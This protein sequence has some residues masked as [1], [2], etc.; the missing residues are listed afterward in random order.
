MSAITK[1]AAKKKKGTSAGTVLPSGIGPTNITN[2]DLGTG[3]IDWSQSVPTSELEGAVIPILDQSGSDPL[4]L[5][6]LLPGVGPGNAPQSLG[7][8]VSSVASMPVAAQ[9]QLAQVLVAADVG[10]AANKKTPYTT[11]EIQSALTTALKEA[12][13]NKSPS[14][15]DFLNQKIG[16]VQAAGIAS[17]TTTS[18][19]AQTIY[20][21][22]DIQATA[23]AV[24]QSVIG[25]KLNANEMQGVLAQMNSATGAKAQAEAAPVP[26]TSTVAGTAGGAVSPVGAGLKQGRTDQGVDYTGA[27]PLYA[28]GSGTILSTSAAGWPGG[29]TYIALKLDNPP[30]PTHD[31]VYYAEGI[32]PGV[33]PGDKVS[34]GQVIGQATG[35]KGGIEIGWG[36][37][38]IGTT[39]AKSTSG[40]TEGQVTSE[41]QHFLSFISGA[42]T[43][44]ATLA[45]VPTGSGLTGDFATDLLN[46]LGA[47]VTPNN[48]KALDAWHQ[49][50]GGNAAFN[51]FNTTQSMTGATN[52]NKVGVKNYAS[53]QD[54]LAATVKALQTGSKSYA[55]ILAALK[56]GNNAIAVADAVGNSQWGTNGI[57]MQSVIVGGPNPIPKSAVSGAAP[58]PTT[59][60]DASS[61]IV[62]I[63]SDPS[64]TEAATNFLETQRSPDYQANN[65]LK[66][67]GMIQSKLSTPASVLNSPVT[68]T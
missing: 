6:N 66:V 64:A 11:A 29:G 60:T 25:R 2:P 43:P 7:G 47:P 63:P 46:Q 41:G 14:L 57:L 18:P 22:A 5:A 31:I 59:P 53:Y 20:T 55:P 16:S 17:T 51:P 35:A 37:A 26:A 4:G 27:G 28:V 10:L 9:Q 40:Y 8:R 24:G 52:Y 19:V 12:S 34:S 13:Q 3:G 58:T 30:D 45:S 39:L 32:T 56:A 23:D 62:Q 50:E 44:S 61:P 33:K 36:S 48:V 65:L 15:S 38:T 68:M 54:G 49:A 67:F 1:P 21:A 42:D